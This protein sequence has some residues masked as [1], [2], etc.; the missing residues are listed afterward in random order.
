MVLVFLF[1]IM[2]SK[3]GPVQVGPIAY[4][5]GLGVNLLALVFVCSLNR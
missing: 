1:P 4:V 5:K 2:A 3:M